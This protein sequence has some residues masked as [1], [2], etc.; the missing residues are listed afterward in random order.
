MSKFELGETSCCFFYGDIHNSGD[1]PKLD[2]HSYACST[3]SSGTSSFDQTETWNVVPYLFWHARCNILCQQ[4]SRCL[5]NMRRMAGSSMQVT[6]VGLM[7]SMLVVTVGQSEILRSW[8]FVI[9]P[10]YRAQ[11]QVNIGCNLGHPQ[12]MTRGWESDLR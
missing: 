2:D 4:H 10:R 6:N 7:I 3:D 1:L 12:K 5:I 8:F 11:Q 9:G